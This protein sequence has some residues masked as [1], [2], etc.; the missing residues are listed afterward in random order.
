MHNFLRKTLLVI[1]FT[2]IA[3]LAC[4]F[5]AQ[6]RESA[7][8]YNVIVVVLD[9][10]RA[11]HLSCYGYFRK[12]T[13]NLDRFASR[14]LLFENCISQACYTLPS[15]AS[16][17]TSKYVHSHNAIESNTR[18]PDKET[19]LAQ[20]LKI[21]GYKTALFAGGVYFE[22]V[23]GFGRGFDSYYAKT[24][25][26]KDGF[27][28]RM[29]KS[30]EIYPK[31]LKWIEENK[32]NKFFIF[33]HSYD[34]YLPIKF[35]P[36]FPNR[37]DPGYRG[38]ADELLSRQRLHLQR[39]S[40]G[41][42]REGRGYLRGPEELELNER[43]KAHIIANYDDGVFYNDMF[44]GRLLEK[45][46]ELN[47]TGKS[48]IILTADHGTDLFD[49][50]T[51]HMYM[52]GS[53]YEE[54]IHVP[55]I[56]SLPRPQAKTA[57]IKTQVQLIDLAPTVLDFLGIPVN[58]GAQGKSLCPVIKGTAPK[59]FNRNV[60]SGWDNIQ[61]VRRLEWKLIFSQGKYELYNLKSDP[62]ELNDLAGRNQGILLGCIKDLFSWNAGLS[63]E[64][65]DNQ[66]ELSPG[67]VRKLKESGY[68]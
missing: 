24:T 2:L 57:R 37:Y 29:G 55:L 32:E 39:T 38:I 50:G 9:A 47:L 46:D 23:Y 11:D 58:S 4:G 21:Y 36:E 56:I 14:S 64:E 6:S 20:V 16:L 41:T 13:P 17:F 8:D 33:I 67:L 44:V 12:T 61:A 22:P 52:D 65:D 27:P 54:V 26:L 5:C 25:E 19:T 40:R 35:P 66:V 1:V 10:L 7:G 42:F 68:W 3:G 49:H 60:F 34:L 28:F 62:H 43:D 59:D 63:P 15:H 45:L 18:L 30:D 31:A 48:L 51:V 53:A